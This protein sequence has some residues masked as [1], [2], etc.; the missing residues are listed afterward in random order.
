MA[1]YRRN[2]AAVN[3]AFTVAAVTVLVTAVVAGV[4]ALSRV[5]DDPTLDGWDTYYGPSDAEIAE[6]Q[7]A[8]K[9]AHP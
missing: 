2:D 3:A 4:Y 1:P 5:P 8:D 7:E 9:E 6:Y